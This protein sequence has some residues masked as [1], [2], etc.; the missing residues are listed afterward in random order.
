MTRGKFELDAPLRMRRKLEIEWS[1]QDLDAVRRSMK[2]LD[3]MGG[4]SRAQAQLFRIK[5]RNILKII[6][7]AEK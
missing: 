1:I 5:L 3:E 2:D 4:L 7:R 6:D